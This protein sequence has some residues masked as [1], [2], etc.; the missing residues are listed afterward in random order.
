MGVDR[1]ILF[2]GRNNSIDVRLK[3]SGTSQ[4]L[5]NT[6]KIQVTFGS[7][8]TIDSSVSPTL[9]SGVTS[10]V[11][12]LSLKFG[13]LTE[14]SANTVYDAEIIVYDDDNINGINWGTIP[15]K[16]EG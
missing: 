2:L 6:T 4:D 5:G 11:G 7:G 16:V 9:F 12:A 8:V 14:I 1:E 10:S 3:A 13:S 15:I